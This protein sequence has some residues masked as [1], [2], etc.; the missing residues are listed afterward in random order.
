MAAA[1]QLEH[2]NNTIINNTVFMITEVGDID[3]GGTALICTTQLT[4]C[5]A[6]RD[7]R[8]GHWYYPNGTEVPIMETGNSFYRIRRDAV[9]GV[10]GGVY[11]NRRFGATSPSGVY[12]CVIPGADG[13]DQTLYVGLYD[14]ENNSEY[15]AWTITQCV[16]AGYIVS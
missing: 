5:C 10:L 16:H 9:G 14:I 15:N 3:S 7:F 8:R 1:V 6:A 11:L 4:P 2:G 12:Q 13:V